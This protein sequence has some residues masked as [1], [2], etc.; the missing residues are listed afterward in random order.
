MSNQRSELKKAYKESRFPMG[1]YQLR[2]TA[3]GKLL[4]GASPDMR[5]RMNRHKFELK[6]RSH[7]NRELQRDWDA[8]G[9]DGFVFEVLAELEPLDDPG[10]D[11]T[12]D[13]QALKQMWLDELQP[14]G[15]RGYHSRP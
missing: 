6:I 15:D 3:N 13:L 12:D 11:P 1:V 9:S 5:A 14:Y 4:I 8:H 2:N 10:Y 7:R